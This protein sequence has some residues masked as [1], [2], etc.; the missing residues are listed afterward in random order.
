MLS[1]FENILRIFNAIFL[2]LCLA[3]A[4]ALVSTQDHV[5]S[6]V[7]I[8][9]FTAAWGLLTDS[10]YGIFANF[11]AVLTW[12]L[13]LVTFD[14]L[15]FVFTFSSATAL[16][17]GIRVHSCG[18][19]VYLDRNGITQGSGNR[20][21]E[22]QALCAFLF[23]STFIFLVKLVMNTIAMFQEG[24]FSSRPSGVRRRRGAAMPD[25]NGAPAISQV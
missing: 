6:R 1:I 19:H 23:F 10:I 14:F 12:P 11:I 3:F 22:A 4:S 25:I 15:G 24:V 18:N 17:V 21:R 7:N 9:L 20:C 16:A 13:F 5:T 2:I 8:C